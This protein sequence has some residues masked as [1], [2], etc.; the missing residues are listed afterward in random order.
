MT[1][2]NFMLNSIFL[3]LAMYSITGVAGMDPNAAD[4][5][6]PLTEHRIE[7]KRVDREE[8]L[9]K[10]LEECNP[11]FAET[12][13]AFVEVADKYDLDYRLLPA[14]SR[15]ESSCGRHY[16]EGTY[17]PFGWGV[18]GNN[19]IGFSSYEEAIETVGKGIKENYINRGFDTP[20]R[21]APIYTPPNHRKWLGAVRSFMREMDEIAMNL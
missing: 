3:P 10:F 15:I 16:I 6:K 9:T 13:E 21:I 5:E 8:V 12:A 1:N 18:Y 4:T 7:A 20:E 2:V 14:I 19:Y 17:N 11:N